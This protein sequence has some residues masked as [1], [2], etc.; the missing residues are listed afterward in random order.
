MR[1]LKYAM[2]DSRLK[3]KMPECLQEHSGTSSNN[4]FSLQ[5]IA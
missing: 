1:H 5:N 3:T 2:A 4:L